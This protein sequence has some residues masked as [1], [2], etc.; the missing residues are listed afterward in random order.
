MKIVAGL[1]NPGA[2]YMRTRH[3][4]GFRVVELLAQRW[5]GTF[6]ELKKGKSWIET[7]TAIGN[8]PVLLVKPMTF[9]NRS[10]ECISKLVR[11]A[12]DTS[13]NLLVIV[14]DLNLPLGKLRFRE[15]GSAGGHNGLKS[16][17]EMLGN[18]SFHR[19][20]LGIAD[21]TGGGGV[22]YVLSKFRP[23]EQPVVEEMLE[24]AADLVEC[25]VKNGAT[26]AMNRFN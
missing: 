24:K 1:G 3:N 2:Q 6:G 23:E 20:R 14:D 18:P 11:N 19:L 8:T 26:A 10:G 12:E 13:G 21:E 17:I 4:L 15:G 25:W 9:M 7:K 5:G 22:D 16:I